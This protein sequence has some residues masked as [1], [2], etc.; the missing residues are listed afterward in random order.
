M[1][2]KYVYR[3]VLNAYIVWN[4]KKKLDKSLF[5]AKNKSIPAKSKWEDD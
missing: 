4:V 2:F 5:L 3:Q 1:E